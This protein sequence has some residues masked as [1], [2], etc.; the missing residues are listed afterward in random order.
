M[1]EMEFSR[2]GF[3]GGAAAFF[4]AGCRS[5]GWLAGTPRLRFGVV[6]DIHLTTPA[7]CAMTER[8]FR[9]FR[10]RGADAVMIPGD[11]TDWGLR[12]G[13]EYLKAT[14]DRVFPGTETVPLFCTGNHDF[15]GWAYGDMTMEMHANGYSEDE[16]LSKLGLAAE[17]ER[18]FGEKYA[19]IRVR[20]VKGYDFIS[21]EWDS[22]GEFPEWMAANGGRFRGDRP[23]FYF[24]HPPAK[25][26]TP[27]GDG[28]ADQGAC[29]KALRG[30]PNAVAFTGHSHRPFNDE[31]SIWQGEF[32]VLAT[33]SL[34]YA[35][36]PPGHE[37]GGGRRNGT[38]VQAMAMIPD[39]RDLRGGQGFFVSVYYDRM[40]V[41]RIDIEEDCAE[42]APA[43]V[44]PLA[45]GGKP[46]DLASR[47]AASVA[48][49]FPS[50]ARL[51]IDTRNTENRSGKWIIALHCEF[52]SAVPPAGA[53]VFDYEMRIVPK[54][55]S[56][57]MVKKFLSPAYSRM[58]KHEPALQR[59]WLDVATLPQDVDYVVEVRAFNC[60]GK[61]SRPLV[62]GVWHSV[63]GLDKVR[64]S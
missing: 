55:A 33:P 45:G 63:P 32:T 46:Y 4:V 53:R 21:A 23:F 47:A 28:W 25:G 15:E 57:P 44:V 34:S 3:I 19:P 26:T 43:W 14:W 13:L 58:A 39:R 40:V 41:E 9:Y 8:A 42:G 18:V 11:L 64:E 2:R 51:R 29:V 22:F 5:G 12:S 59:F 35:C 52:P 20:T 31:R 7:S 24:Q 61:A 37:N 48:P 49:E 62:S 1:S 50:D 54:D 27:D 56:A 30:F 16:A 36:F 6:S 17:W 60:F 38:S 10:A